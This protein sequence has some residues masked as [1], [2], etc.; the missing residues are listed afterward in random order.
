MIGRVENFVESMNPVRHATF[1]HRR[2]RAVQ[3]K[4]PHGKRLLLLKVNKRIA[5][6]VGSSRE[7]DFGDVRVEVDGELLLERYLCWL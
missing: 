4:I 2:G 5:R 1:I 7:I 6:G 3:E